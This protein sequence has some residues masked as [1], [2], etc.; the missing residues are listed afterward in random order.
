VDDVE[1][2]GGDKQ[3]ESERGEVWDKEELGVR[4]VERVGGCEGG[5]AGKRGGGEE[6]GV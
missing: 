2:R 1:A 3:R 5:V 4:S 6:E